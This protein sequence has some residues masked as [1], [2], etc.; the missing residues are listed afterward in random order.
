MA[1]LYVIRIIPV[2]TIRI[3]SFGEENETE[4]DHDLLNS[5]RDSVDT[6]L[7]KSISSMDDLVLSIPLLYALGLIFT[8]YFFDLEP[9][10]P[11]L[12]LLYGFIGIL[13]ILVLRIGKIKHAVDFRLLA[14]T[15]TVQFLTVGFGLALVVLLNY[16]ST[17][18]TMTNFSFI[19]ITTSISVGI[20]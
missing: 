4:L 18:T 16:A 19:F 9:I 11:Q 1:I 3:A 10:Q 2:I 6:F 13:L 7:G 12:N 14:V 17:M 15:S 8:P 5:R 20:I